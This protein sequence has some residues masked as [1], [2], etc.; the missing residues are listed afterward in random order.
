[1][2]EIKYALP[3]P[4]STTSTLAAAIAIGGTSVDFADAS[5]FSANDFVLLEVQGHEY[6]EILKIDSK[7]GD[8]VTFTAGAVLP[9][10]SGITVSKLSYDKYRIEES[11]NNS[12]WT[13]LV[14]GDLDYSHKHQQIVYEY[15]SWSKDNYYRI[16]Y[17]NSETSTAAVQATQ[18]NVDQFG[19]I[20]L[21]E[22]RS[23]PDIPT[24]LEDSILINAI[25]F[26]REYIRDKAFTYRIVRTS[27]RDTDYELDLDMMEFADWNSTGNIN[28]DDFIIYEE[29]NNGIKTYLPHK[30]AKIWPDS[31]RILFS[32]TVPT[33]NSALVFWAPATFRQYDRIKQSLRLVNK[34]KAVNYIL[35]NVPISQ[36]STGGP[37]WTAGGTTVNKEPTTIQQTIKENEEIIKKE[38]TNL[39]KVY[40]R[41]SRLR[42]TGSQFRGR[43]GRRGNFTITTQGGVTY[44]I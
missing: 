35:S 28:V 14:T 23:E 10:S 1:M 4:T 34:L 37:S 42:D 43:G 19:W 18:N 26:G 39:V 30:V 9:H 40:I 3:S 36:L 16:S 27:E 41:P 20:T 6:C 7:S 8:T 21:A 11:K 5:S 13:T 44:R 15:T 38:M 25:L 24:H 22:L 29:D 32:E 12:D 31:H 33:T 2:V 17:Y